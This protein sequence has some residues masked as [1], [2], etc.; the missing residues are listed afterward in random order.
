MRPRCSVFIATTLDGFI[1]RP[2]GGIDWLSVVERAGE[3][4]G[5][6]RFWASID[7]LVIGRNTYEMAC[8]F[9]EWPYVGKRCIVM[10]H[11]ELVAKH[12]EERFAGSPRELVDRLGAE[13]VTRIYV[14]GGSII[15]QFLAAGLV[16]DLT[17]S[18]VPVL[19]GEGLP[20]FGKTERD[21]PLELV[22]SRSF[23]SGLVQVEYRVR[24]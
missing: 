6:K 23:P 3:D 8:G 24:A 12:G 16:S 7:A 13:G 21:L 4:Y 9:S 19:L 15:R 11:A 14:D 22:E 18:I 17:I 20:L 10:T 2:D 5:Y 1:A